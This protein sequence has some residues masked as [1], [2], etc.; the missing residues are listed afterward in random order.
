MNLFLTQEKDFFPVPLTQKFSYLQQI[1]FD[2]FEI[3]GKLLLHHFDDVQKAVNATGF[4]V[5][6]ACG[7][8]SGWIGDF[9]EK[10]REKGIKEISIILEKLSELGARGI[11]IP[12]AWGMFSLRLPPMVPPRSAEEDERVLSDSLIQ[13]NEVAA[14]N[15]VFL[16]LEPLNRYEDHMINTLAKAAYYIKTYSL[17]NVK[18]IADFYHMNIEEAIIEESILQQRAYIQH[19]HLADSHRYQPGSGHID[20]EKGFRALKQIGYNGAMSFE[21][22]VLGDDAEKAYKQS[23]QYIKSIYSKVWNE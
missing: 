3:D 9:D 23:L 17:L 16:F 7:G 1:G 15:N 2:G 12:A 22:R 8:Y 20:F 13:L 10:K 4:P 11:V 21:C 5:V 14:K 19:I 18:I 6:S